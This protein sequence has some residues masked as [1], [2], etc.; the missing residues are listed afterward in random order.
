MTSTIHFFR[1]PVAIKTH[2][3]Q[4]LLRAAHQAGLTIKHSCGGKGICGACMVRIQSGE[5]KPPSAEEAACLGE[6]KLSQGYRL[7]CLAETDGDAEIELL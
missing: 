4:T 7:A 6:E 2:S 3:G 5:V 1:K